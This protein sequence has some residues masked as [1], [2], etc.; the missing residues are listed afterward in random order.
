MLD[1]RF[2]EEVALWSNEGSIQTSTMLV[3]LRMGKP[4]ATTGTDLGAQHHSVRWCGVAEVQYEYST[5]PVLHYDVYICTLGV[6]SDRRHTSGLMLHVLQ[7]TL[8]SVRVDA[9]LSINM[10]Q[11][12]ALGLVC[13]GL[14]RLLTN[15]QASRSRQV[16][17][18]STHRPSSRLL[19]FSLDTTY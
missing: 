1:V 15:S 6:R 18:P 5:G 3:F 8:A 17:P 7:Y 14:F 10:S 19:S 9:S 12:N 16:H 4:S 13:L 2:M 11:R